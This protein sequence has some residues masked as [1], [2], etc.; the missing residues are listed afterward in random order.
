MRP[1]RSISTV[2][3]FEGFGAQAVEAATAGVPSV[4]SRAGALPEA[5]QERAVYVDPGDPDAVAEALGRLMDSSEERRRAG[6]AFDHGGAGVP[7]AGAR[8]EL[9]ERCH[10]AR[11][12]APLTPNVPPT[13]GF[14]GSPGPFDARRPPARA[15]RRRRA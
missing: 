1:A 15:A 12:T 14:H 8:R 2:S 7:L 4:V 3:L 13:R 6:A 9:L 11:G 10:A 5:T